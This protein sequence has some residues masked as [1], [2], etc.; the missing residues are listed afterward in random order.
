MNAVR[1]ITATGRLETFRL[2][3]IDMEEKW[4]FVAIAVVAKGVDGTVLMS[5]A[6][7]AVNLGIGSQT[8]GDDKS[9]EAVAKF[10]D[11]T[12]RTKDGDEKYYVMHLA[13]PAHTVSADTLTHLAGPA[14]DIQMIPSQ[15]ELAFGGSPK[16]KG[17][18]RG[19]SKAGKKKDTATGDLGV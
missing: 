15:T 17:K 7:T 19:K 3:V 2:K 16:G 12:L 10:V 11:Y 1:Q 5:L 14:I 4:L 9:V 8:D 18:A 6:G 13:I